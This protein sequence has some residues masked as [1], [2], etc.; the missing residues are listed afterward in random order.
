MIEIDRYDPR[1][2]LEALKELF[3]DFNKN[4][5][6]YPVEWKQFERE[7]RLRVLDLQYRNSMIIAKENGG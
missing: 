7:L 3:D 2:D 4:I 1:E 5:S 6:Y